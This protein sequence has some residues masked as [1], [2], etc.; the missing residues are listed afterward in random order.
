MF[1]LTL[2]KDSRKFWAA[3]KKNKLLIQRTINSNK[4]FLYSRGH[5]GAIAEDD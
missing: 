3:A 4:F 5:G 1:N 2:D